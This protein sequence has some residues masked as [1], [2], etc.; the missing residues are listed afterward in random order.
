MRVLYVNHPNAPNYAGGDVVVMRRMAGDLRRRGV[1][2]DEA[3]DLRPNA[4]GF[5]VA[6]LF[7]SC[8]PGDRIIQVESL[9]KTGGAAIVLTPTYHNRPFLLWAGACLRSIYESALSDDELRKRLDRLRD[10]RLVVEEPGGRRLHGAADPGDDPAYLNEQRRLFQMVDLLLPSGLLEACQMTRTVKAFDVPFEVV[11]YVVD[12]DP[13]LDADPDLFRSR[14]GL[15]DFVLMAGR[16]EPNK[17][18]ILLVEALRGLDLP[19]VVVGK[20]MDQGYLQACRR[21]AGP[22]VHFLPYL[23]IDELRSAYAAARVH[24]LPSFMETCGLVTM[25]AALADCNVVVSTS[26]YEVE[27]FQQWAYY[28]D[29]VDVDSIRAAVVR[30]YDAWPTDGDRRRR[31]RDWI[32]ANCS[33]PT[34]VEQLLDIYRRLSPRRPR[35][36]S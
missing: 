28:C 34:V 25:E 24:A 21:R 15:S 36:L 29:P 2:V 20:V 5:D 33:T 22:N 12:P 10:R 23:P 4:A 8:P 31:L 27:H 1:D 14:F 19:L 13:F 26:G 18:Q 7:N 17:N 16:V 32:V 9:R 30:A 6:H 3:F 11:R 35:S